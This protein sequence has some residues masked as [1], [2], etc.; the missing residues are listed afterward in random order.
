MPLSGSLDAQMVEHT[1][2]NVGD[3]HRGTGF[4]LKR[5]DILLHAT[6]WINFEKVM[7]SEI[8]Q[9][10]KDKYMIPQIEVPDIVKFIDTK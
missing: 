6:T 8:S 9:T 3:T 1:H 4:S 7:L 2:T 5:Q 10:E